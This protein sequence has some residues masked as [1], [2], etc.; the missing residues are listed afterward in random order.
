MASVP[1]SLVRRFGPDRRVGE[2]ARP[3]T[4]AWPQVSWGDHEARRQDREE[5]DGLAEPTVRGQGRRGRPR[6]AVDALGP[7]PLDPGARPVP[8]RR[9]RAGDGRGRRHA[10]RRGPDR[11]GLEDPLGGGCDGRGGDPPHG[12]GRGRR[13]RPQDGGTG[14]RLLPA[15]HGDEQ[16]RRLPPRRRRARR[17]DHR[18]GHRGAGE[19]AEDRPRPALRT[20]P[21]LRHGRAGSGAGQVR[22][23]PP[24]P[25]PAARRTGNS[26]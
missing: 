18:S 20:R 4:A 6:A 24:R 13:D 12:D 14:R 26:S 23:R 17:L 16:G 10:P 2:E 21:L 7:T 25:V 3:R 19:R 8:R 9:R 1:G 5:C 15:A 11:P 22:H